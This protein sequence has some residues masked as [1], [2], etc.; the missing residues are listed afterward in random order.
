MFVTV[1]C[2]KIDR[3]KVQLFNSHSATPK[4]PEYPFSCESSSFLHFGLPYWDL[5]SISTPSDGK[6]IIL[7]L[8]NLKSLVKY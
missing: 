4:T 5:T 2:V 3:H 6:E 1:D 8:P 7:I